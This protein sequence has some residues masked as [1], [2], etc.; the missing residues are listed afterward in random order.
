MFPGDNE[1]PQRHHRRARK[2]L[3]Q[4]AVY[5]AGP[6]A[7]TPESLQD[8]LQAFGISEAQINAFISHKTASE[9]PQT[10]KNILYRVNL[11]AFEW[12]DEVQESLKFL[13]LANGG[14]ICQGL[15]LSQVAADLQLNPRDYVKD[16]Y[17]RL[18]RLGQYVAKEYNRASP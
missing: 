2:K 11:V 13:P 14:A 3:K 7:T 17:Q 5:F 8:D 15:D 1:R 18:K 9:K 10:E 6:P 16:D 4:L 12:F